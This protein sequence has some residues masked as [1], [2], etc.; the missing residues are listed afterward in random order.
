MTN[1]P[2]V[3]PGNDF[4][5]AKL[6]VW[7]KGLETKVNG[8]TREFDLLKND[9]VKKNCVMKKDVKSAGDE[10]IELKHEQNKTLEKMDLIVKEL[11]RTAGVEEL[12]VL[13][14]Y[15][16]FWNPM[17]FVTQ[18]DLDREIEKRLLNSEAK[19][20]MAWEEG[21]KTNKKEKHLPFV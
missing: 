14:K 5:L 4:D 7:I 20:T 19:N 8:L 6:Y 18:K 12:Q 2:P 9:F 17:H 16:D 11:K 10:M 3:Q 15:I 1:K 13:K 21:E